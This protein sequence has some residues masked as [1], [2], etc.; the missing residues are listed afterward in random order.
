MYYP[1]LSFPNDQSMK[2]GVRV[3]YLYHKACSFCLSFGGMRRIYQFL[4][5]VKNLY[6]QKVR[7]L[8]DSEPYFSNPA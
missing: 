2:V 7:S 3:N 1:L 5:S 8:E 6:F 4:H